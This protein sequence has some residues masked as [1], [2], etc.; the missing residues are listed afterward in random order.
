MDRGRGRIA[1]Q[2]PPLPGLSD[3]LPQAPLHLYESAPLRLAVME[4][5]PFAADV[6]EDV[7]V[8]H[9]IASHD[10]PRAVAA[11]ADAF[12]TDAPAWLL[13]RSAPVMGR[14]VIRLSSA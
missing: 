7:R 5:V 10:P 2:L 9:L 6:H 1:E 12:G 11:A 4:S 14:P 8:G 3:P 13:D